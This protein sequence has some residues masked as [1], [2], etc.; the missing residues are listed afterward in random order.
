LSYYFLIFFIG[1]NFNNTELHQ[2]AINEINVTYAKKEKTE[3][4]AVLCKITKV[5]VK[6]SNK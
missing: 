4:N 1:I 5:G 3:A 2:Y 6:V